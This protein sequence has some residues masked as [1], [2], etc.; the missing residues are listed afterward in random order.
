MLRS[1]EVS[2]EFCGVDEVESK[3]APFQKQ[4]GAATKG[5]R[6]DRFESGDILLDDED[7]ADFDV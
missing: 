6:G 1:Y 3:S 2:D 7:C 4:K 5:R